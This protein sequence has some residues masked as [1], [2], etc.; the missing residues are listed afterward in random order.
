MKK[1]SKSLQLTETPTVFVLRR[2]GLA[3][4]IEWENF[5]K[6]IMTPMPEFKS[7]LAVV[8]ELRKAS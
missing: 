3:A 8:V 2:P 7:I 6:N 1:K 4:Y 5:E